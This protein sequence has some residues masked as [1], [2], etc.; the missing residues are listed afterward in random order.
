[1]KTYFKVILSFPYI[2]LV[3]YVYI[4][5]FEGYFYEKMIVLDD[6]VDLSS[7]LK[8]LLSLV[9]IILLIDLWQIKKLIKN[10]KWL[11]TFILLIFGPLG[12][13]Y[14]IWKAEKELKGW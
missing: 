3:M 1:M 14:Y 4:I 8:I 11:W 7:S 2:L 5:F 12:A 10:R 9:L 13:L 6:Y